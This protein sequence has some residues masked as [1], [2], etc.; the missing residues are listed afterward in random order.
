MHENATRRPGSPGRGEFLRPKKTRDDV[1]QA[2]NIKFTHVVLYVIVGRDI[3]ISLPPPPPPLSY[4]FRHLCF[5][6]FNVLPRRRRR[7]RP[8]LSSRPSSTISSVCCIRVVFA[9][10][11]EKN[12]RL[13]SI[14]RLGPSAV[15][16]SSPPRRRP[17]LDKL[18]SLVTYRFDARSLGPFSLCFYF[19]SDFFPLFPW[20]TDRRFLCAPRSV[21][22]PLP[23][24][25]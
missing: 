23:S 1:L 2:E 7:H 10:R 3:I 13:P 25:Q 19:R 9:T 15:P 21:L 20:K 4:E 5:Y 11:R 22:A 14:S 18:F 12:Y 6:R 17:L 24:W 16:Q 8:N